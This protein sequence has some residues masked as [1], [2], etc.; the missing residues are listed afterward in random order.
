MLGFMS[1][2]HIYTYDRQKFSGDWPL[3][4]PFAPKVD[5]LEPPLN[6]MLSQ[7]TCTTFIRVEVNC[8]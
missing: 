7:I 6:I 1:K 4:R 5:V 8:V 2:V 3:R